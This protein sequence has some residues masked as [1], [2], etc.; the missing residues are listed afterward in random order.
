MMRLCTN[1]HGVLTSPKHFFS[2]NFAQ[3][4]NVTTDTRIRKIETKIIE[5]KPKQE[6]ILGNPV[7]F[8]FNWFVFVSCLGKSSW[9]H[10]SDTDDNKSKIKNNGKPTN[11]RFPAIV[12]SCLFI[13][14]ECYGRHNGRRWELQHHY[15]R[16]VA[17]ECRHEGFYT[18]KSLANMC[19]SSKAFDREITIFQLHFAETER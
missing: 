19:L 18:Q 5:K 10:C 6:P 16:I 15:W 9:C 2:C 1:A 11:R 3:A 4:S 8:H 17:H 14:G 7:H 13:G 12:L